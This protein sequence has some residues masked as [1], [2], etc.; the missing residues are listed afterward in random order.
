MLYRLKPLLFIKVFRHKM[1]S[2]PKGTILVPVGAFVSFLVPGERVELS[3]DCSHGFLKPARLPVPPP[4]HAYINVFK[5]SFPY[6]DFNCF[7]RFRA[8]CHVLKFSV[9]INRKGLCGLVVFSLP[10]LCLANLFSRF[11]VNPTYT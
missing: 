3:R 10:L 5:N 4:G 7:S 1:P 9:R 8:S 6:P 2:S 11:F